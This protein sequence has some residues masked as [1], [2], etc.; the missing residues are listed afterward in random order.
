MYATG[1]MLEDLAR[2]RTNQT[3]SALVDRAP[4][5]AHRIEGPDIVDV[6]VSEVERGESIV[7]KAGEKLDRGTR[8]PANRSS[9]PRAVAPTSLGESRRSRD[10]QRCCQTFQ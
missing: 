1:Q 3:L 8:A 6:D 2:Q 9:R 4:S 5:I 10:D 7:V